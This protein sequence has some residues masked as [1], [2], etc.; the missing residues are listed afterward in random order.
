MITPKTH[1]FL[2]STFANQQRQHSAQPAPEVVLHPTTRATGGC[3][4]AG[5]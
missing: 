4:T 2:N 1:L 5:R 3:S